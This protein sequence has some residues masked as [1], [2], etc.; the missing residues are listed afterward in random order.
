MTLK[1]LVTKLYRRAKKENKATV[2][3]AKVAAIIPP[4]VRMTLHRLQRISK[5]QDILKQYDK[6]EI[7]SQTQLYRKYELPESALQAGKTEGLM[8]TTEQRCYTCQSP[9][10][11]VH[12]FYHMLCPSC[13]A[14]NYSKRLQ[15]ADLRGRVAVITGGRIKIGY[16]TALR[17]LRDG[18]K[19]WVTTRFAK[20]CALRFS[21]EKDFSEWSH[22]LKIAALDLRNL[23]QV[24]QLIEQLY[25]EESHLDILIHN[26]AQ[27]VKRPTAF[28]QHLFARE[29]SPVETLP[30]A[31]RSC[32]APAPPFRYLGD[33]W[34][35][36]LLPAEVHQCFPAGQYDKDRQQID[37]RAS[38]SWTLRLDQVPPGEML[39]TQ[40]VNVTA[41]F[42]FNSKLKALMK[43]SPFPRRFIIN[44]SA[45]EGQ[46]NRGSKT[47]YHPHTN[48]AK[49][50]LNMMTRT[51]A[52][53]YAVDGIFM[54]SVD[55]GWITQ[56]NPHPKKERIYEEDGFVP[57]LDET[58][59]MA[60]IYDP[61]VS[62]LGNPEIPLFGHFLKDY[63]PYAW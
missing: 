63:L 34:E 50:A 26:A 25:A 10:R 15:R 20:D 19:V 60:R 24:N 52:Q 46:F 40:L 51:S 36:Q 18:A 56:E 1:G 39:E 37:L 41:P 38:N 57:P 59:G 32:L 5:Q 54:N 42:M 23:G 29:E 16:L 8:L 27:T 33:A 43:K 53:D 35:Q 21:E 48:M 13:A 28:Y 44:V 2:A 6:K 45:M 12:F 55:T 14:L 31:V 7:L 17:M 58:D 61:V 9:Y 49:A 47:P 30:E 22:R 3:E 11:E 62:G 4:E